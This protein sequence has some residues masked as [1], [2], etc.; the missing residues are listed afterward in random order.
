[1]IDHRGIPAEHIGRV[2]VPFAQLDAGIERRFGGA[3]VGMA[4]GLC[5]ADC[6][7][8]IDELIPSSTANRNVDPIGFA[9]DSSGR[10]RVVSPRGAD[11]C[12]SSRDGFDA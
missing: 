7:V 1:M 3:G 11:P 9:L 10:P 12:D 4:L 6:R 2:F 8:A 5:T